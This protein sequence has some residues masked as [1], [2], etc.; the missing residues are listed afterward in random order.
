MTLSLQRTRN[1]RV[2]GSNNLCACLCPLF[3]TCSCGIYYMGLWPLPLVVIKKMKINLMSDQEKNV[4]LAR[5]TGWI[6]VDNRLGIGWI[7]PRNSS[8]SPYPKEL[9][10]FYDY[11]NM[12]LAW[13][14]LNWATDT[15]RRHNEEMC[16]WWEEA[17]IHNRQPPEAQRTWLDKT[18]ELE[19]EEMIIHS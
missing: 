14:V 19:A 3:S 10:N 5:M 11:R 7:H 8:P 13:E 16:L 2:N 18:I 12:D 9:P 15:E 1:E 17:R 6:Y 4:L